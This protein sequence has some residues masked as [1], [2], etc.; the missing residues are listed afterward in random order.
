MNLVAKKYARALRESF[1][2]NLE[3]LLEVLGSLKS[4]YTCADFVE[5]LESPYYPNSYKQAFLCERLED[6]DERLV[7]FLELLGEHKRLMIIPDIYQ[8][9]YAWTQHQR[10]VYKGY[11]Y[12]DQ[13]VEKLEV[14][15]KQVAKHLNITLELESV[16]VQ[17]EGIKLEIPDLGVE[18]AFCKERFFH[19]LK[20]HIMEA[21]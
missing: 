21:I 3:H 12:C 7:R 2:G 5:F 18:V 11:L 20:H 9:L 8:E 19:Q 17:H 16:L 10:N 1:T 14:L 6:K 13:A 15:E 4:L